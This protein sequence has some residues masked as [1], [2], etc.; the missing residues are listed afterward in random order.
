MLAAIVFWLTIGLL[1]WVYVGYPVLVALLARLRPLR[2]TLTN[3]SP[4][5]TVAIAV[6]DGEGEIGDRIA[7]VLHQVD[8]RTHIS[9]VL[10]G[11]DGSTDRTDSIVRD[12]ASGD[13]RIR[14]LSLPRGGQSATQNALLAASSGEVLVLTDAETRYLPGC[15]AALADVFRD[16]RV[17]C[18]TGR[19][20]WRDENATATS[21]NE[22]LYW[23]YERTLRELESRAGFLTAVTGALLA[24]RRTTCRAVPPS[25][26]MD[27]VIPLYARE[28]G[29]SV[30]YVADAI[31]TDRPISGLREQFWNRARTAT[32]GIQ[33]NLS[34]VGRLTPWRH[35]TPALSIW[36]HKLM[37]WATPW[38]IGGAALSGLVLALDGASAYGVVPILVLVGLAAAVGAQVMTIAGWRPPRFMAFCRAFS[39]VNLAFAMAWINVLRR[40][41][42]ETW[43]PYG[44]TRPPGVG[45]ADSGDAE[46]TNAERT[47][48][49]L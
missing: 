19:L 45:L 28:Q 47:N 22:G 34:M 9:E 6:H 3:A 2:L 39:V 17:G 41:H 40:Q 5:L 8:G 10:V 18:A 4:T 1:G 35:A 26:S 16:P 20:D 31:A 46:R 12:L 27:Q 29:Q 11:S 7:N 30:V 13:P 14:L 33:A 24:V 44:S 23:R 36:S 25:T 38:L 21:Q 42:F 15:L 49:P 32:Q 37:R 43:T 48:A